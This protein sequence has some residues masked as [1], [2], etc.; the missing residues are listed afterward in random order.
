MGRTRKTI[1]RR[2]GLVILAAGILF[3]AAAAPVF[4]VDPTLPT[5]FTIDDVQVVKNVAATGDVLVAFKYTIH[6]NSGQPTTPANSLF[7]FRL[8]AADGVTEIGAIQP[9]AYNNSGYDMGYSAF[10]FDPLTAPTWESALVLKMAGN[11]QY[12]GV[13]PITNYTLVTSDYSQLSS[14]SENQKLLG[15]WIISISRMLEVDWSVKLLTET[16][17]STILNDTGAAYGKGTIPGLQ[18][19]APKVF[20][21]QSQSLDTSRRTWTTNEAD[22]WGHQWEGT[23]VGDMLTGLQNL[24]HQG[25]WL[26]LTT[27]MVF[28]ICIAFFIWGFVWIQDNSA[29]MLASSHVLAGSTAMG[30]FHP[31]ALA[32]IVLL[33]GGITGW[34]IWGDKS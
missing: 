30:L 27:L 23:V 17:Q 14:R 31:G 1:V 28:V 18:N 13:P 34:Q 24:F 26:V 10:Y 15:D 9:Y 29:A 25:N 5:V 20:A 32:V 6:Y 2:I 12:W 4:A 3:G 7:H 33:Y 16:A 21:V 11:P 22:A 8:F 19:L